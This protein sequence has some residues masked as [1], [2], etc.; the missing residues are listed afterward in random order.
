MKPNIR[1]VPSAILLAS[2]ITAACAPSDAGESVTTDAET[3]APGRLVIIGGAL[4]AENA[5]VYE[6]VLEARDGDGPVCVI[7]TAGGDPVG[8]METMVGRIEGYAGQGTALGIPISTDTPELVY[9]SA[10]AAQITACS[11]FYFTGGDQSRIVQ[12]FLPQGEET[13]AYEALWDRWQSG[14]VLAGSS[15][16]AAMMSQVMI[17]GGNPAETVMHGLAEGEDDEGM[18]IT[19]GMGFFTASILD[20]HFLA[21]G[22]IGRSLVAALAIDSLGVSLGIDENTAMVVEGDSAVVIGESGVVVVDARGAERQSRIRGTGIRVTLAG[23]GDVVE[24]GTFGVRRDESKDPVPVADGPAPEVED[25]LARWAFLRVLHGLASTPATHATFSAG[26][27]ELTIAE[28]E[29]FGAWMHAADGGVEG[30][31]R[32]FSAG[33]FLVDLTESDMQAPAG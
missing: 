30:A 5:A 19:G 7:P 9:D 6:A 1:I 11:G 16:G 18:T 8:S 27:V 24:L 25:P 14:A 23:A 22:R 20:Q 4:D 15:A 28:G 3:P 21:R 31:P 10:T 26:G 2:T 12:V 29:G 13:P 33:T 32:G 17:S